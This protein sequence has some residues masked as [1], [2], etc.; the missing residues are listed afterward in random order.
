MII[1]SSAVDSKIKNKRYR[2][3][4]QKQSPQSPK[5]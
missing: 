1:N 2:N 4:F 3:A 5:N